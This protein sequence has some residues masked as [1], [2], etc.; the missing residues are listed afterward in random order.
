LKRDGSLIMRKGVGQ[1]DKFLGSQGVPLGKTE[2]KDTI[3]RTIAS[4]KRPPLEGN[5]SERGLAIPR[6]GEL[7]D[8]RQQGPPIVSLNK[9]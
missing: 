6:G 7:W 4:R 9:G 1:G 2:E 5:D 3:Q 8:E